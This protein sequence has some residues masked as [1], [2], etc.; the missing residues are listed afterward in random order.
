M[1]TYNIDVSD[2]LVNG[3]TRVLIEVLE[4]PIW[5][6][7]RKITLIAYHNYTIVF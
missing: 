2:G 4:N 6:V 3:T 7:D 5:T 1:I